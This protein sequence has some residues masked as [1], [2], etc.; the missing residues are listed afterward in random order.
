M[1]VEEELERT[2][3]LRMLRLRGEW[4]NMRSSRAR[5]CA[6]C[7]LALGG[8]R[9]RGFMFMWRGCRGRAARSCDDWCVAVPGVYI[10]NDASQNTSCAVHPT[11]PRIN[12]TLC[13]TDNAAQD[14]GARGITDD[15]TGGTMKFAGAHRSRPPTS[16]T[17]T[18]NITIRFLGLCHPR[19]LSREGRIR[20][21]RRRAPP[22]SP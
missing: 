8:R 1:V 7:V 10:Y 13:T 19:P 2:M 21:P 6:A 17:H 20:A 16:C 5:A 3:R 9:K 22:S 4:R 14:H 15:R 12:I 11:A 18:H